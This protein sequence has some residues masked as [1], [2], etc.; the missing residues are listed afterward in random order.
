MTM[1]SA[2][3]WPGALLLGGLAA[4]AATSA[5]SACPCDELLLSGLDAALGHT[6]GQVYD[7]SYSLAADAAAGEH[8]VYLRASNGIYIYYVE[9][10]Q[11]WVIGANV[12]NAAGL[13]INA[14]GGADSG[15]PAGLPS[16]WAVLGAVEPSVSLAC[17]S[18][19]P[20]PP[21]P[22]PLPPP[23]LPPPPPPLPP[24]SLPPPSPPPPG[25]PPLPP[26]LSPPQPPPPPPPPSPPPQ[27]SAR[28][29]SS[30]PQGAADS[31]ILA[32]DECAECDDS[33]GR[34]GL[35]GDGHDVKDCTQTCLE[36]ASCQYAALSSSGYCH[37]F[38]T[39]DGTG[40][41]SGWTLFRKPA[42]QFPAWLHPPSN[43]PPSFPS[44][45][46]PP[47]HPPLPPF[48][49]GS[50]LVR[51]VAELR[52]AIRGI[53]KEIVLSPGEYLLGSPLVIERSLKLRALIPRTAVLD[54]NSSTTPI[55]IKMV[56]LAD[57]IDESTGQCRTTGDFHKCWDG[58]DHC[59]TNPTTNPQV[60]KVSV[61]GLIIRNGI[62]THDG[63]KYGSDT[64]SRVGGGIFAAA[65]EACYLYLKVD[66]CEFN[67]NV[68][69]RAGVPGSAAAS[70][71][72]SGGAIFTK[73]PVYLSISNSAFRRNRAYQ[74]RY[75][76][77]G[78]YDGTGGALSGR[79]IR[80]LFIDNAIFEDNHA[81]FRGHHI[82]AHTSARE[83]YDGMEDGFPVEV[84]FSP[85]G[86]NRPCPSM[87][88]QEAAQRC[89]RNFIVKN[90]EFGPATPVNWGVIYP[91]DYPPTTA[92]SIIGIPNTLNFYCPVGMWMA[93]D[94]DVK[95][96]FTGCANNCSAGRFGN[97]SN[98]KAAEDCE[99]CPKGNTCPEGSSEPTP[100]QPG[101]FMATVGA[102][103]EC[104]R[105]DYPLWSGNG[106]EKCDICR[107][108][109]YLRDPNACTRDRCAN[110]CSACP[111]HA[112]CSAF[113]TSLE[114][115]FVQRGHWRASPISDKLAKCRKLGGDDDAGKVRCAG[116][117]NTEANG[118]GLCN[119][120]F[121][122][123]ECQLCS[124]DDHYLVDGHK[125]EKCDES[126]VAA[127]RLIGLALGILIACGL[128]ATAF[129]MRSWRKQRLV[130][131]PLR[132]ADRAVDWCLAIGLMAKVKILLGFYQVRHSVP[133]PL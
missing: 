4:S 80:A 105:C 33:N 43:P 63:I 92:K 109:F 113:N 26:S 21:P 11:V 45:P 87:E 117:D 107:S 124:A 44:P 97:S 34:S 12:G 98:L 56:G 48:P 103:D 72:G 51:T 14:E 77:T 16:E 110:R 37:T 128:L 64:A 93:N 75:W 49:P 23:P 38:T 121:K 88:F 94:F 47:P 84:G 32:C 59:P 131:P 69:G 73:L 133:S 82:M 108:G 2:L 15:C 120:A 61:E 114:T 68:A 60:E 10:E 58:L 29:E 91:P 67:D 79:Q 99:L 7:G 53:A 132:F 95:D 74:R 78:D 54:G 42:A 112:N 104:R 5:A 71:S 76:Y 39:C 8:H 85:P 125:C 52:A 123:P 119:P 40:G 50:E 106:S 83:I 17:P 96:P 18:S 115:L 24:P 57:E 3:P 129:S 36:K 118:K 35:G 130:G 9:Q 19:P 13:A 100:C 30:P 81:D 27:S 126:A 101:T 1:T 86:D 89:G 116:G 31:M 22:P 28:F 66:D 127:G 6:P 62:A 111:P 70:F 41:G 122:G 46:S 20:L 65:G 102:P 55:Y 90:S 25:P